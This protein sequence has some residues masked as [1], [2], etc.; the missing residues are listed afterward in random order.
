MYPFLVI[1]GAVDHHS[2]YDNISIERQANNQNEEKPYKY[3][4]YVRVLFIVNV[5]PY[6]QVL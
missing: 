1:I 5:V 6:I 4:C 3:K 2:T